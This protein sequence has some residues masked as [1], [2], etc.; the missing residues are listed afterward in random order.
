MIKQAMV[1][2]AGFGKRIYPLTLQKPKPLLEISNTTLLANTLKFLASHGIEKVVINVHYLADQIIDYIDKNNFNLEI[3]I[4]NEKN[5]ILDTGGGILHAIKNFS[6]DPFIVVNPDTIWNS[7]YLKELDLIEK[8]F[9]VNKN[10]KCSILVVN[11]EKSFD[12]SFKGDFS[13][14]SNKINKKIN[15]LDYI[16]TGLQ[17]VQPN[18]FLNYKENIFS[19]NKIWNDLIINNELYGVESNIEFLHISTLKIY[20]EI[21]KKTNT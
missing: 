14:E 3:I 8:L 7:N 20:E 6:K 17:V 5:K 12:K 4:S 18:I 21:L 19:M 16:Y 1:L 11:K 15:C 9:E 10:I 2:S 13:L